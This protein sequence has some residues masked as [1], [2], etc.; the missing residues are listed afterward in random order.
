MGFCFSLGLGAAMGL[1]MTNE[2][3]WGGFHPNY[4]ELHGELLVRSFP[5]V[6][7]QVMV[8]HRAIFFAAG[9][10]VAHRAAV[11]RL[12]SQPEVEVL[13]GDEGFQLL[14][15]GE[16][17]LRIE[18]H[19]EFTTFTVFAPQTGEPFV[20]AATD[21]LPEG[22]L[23]GIPGKTLVAVEIAGELVAAIDAGTVKT[24]EHVL[25]FFD[26]GRLVG[27]WVVERVASV[28]SHF[29]PDERGATRFLVQIH[30]LTSGRYGRLLQ[31]LV[32]IE[33]HR[34]VALLG[35]PAAREL[36]KQVD[37]LDGQHARLVRRIAA[38]EDRTE[39]AIE[40]AELAATAGQLHAQSAPRLRRTAAHAQILAARV[41]ELR[42]EQVPGYPTLGEFFDRRLVPA[43]HSCETAAAALEGFSSRLAGTAAVLQ[44]RPAADVSP[45]EIVKSSNAAPEVVREV[46][47]PALPVE[48]WRQ[49]LEAA[50][51][52]AVVALLAGLL[53]WIWGMISGRYGD[54]LVLLG[55][56]LALALCGYAGWLWAVRHRRGQVGGAASP[57]PHADGRRKRS[58]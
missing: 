57:G 20:E 19:D 10:A 23:E 3:E 24:M 35:L 1:A 54:S 49:P 21:R 29:R 52:V 2:V 32:E 16:V 39:L 8:S 4:R 55:V 43:W 7:G 58:P 56:A 34:M 53:Q 28:W 18:Q 31:R 40:L 17:E 37:L 46:M 38:G 11:S 51:V 48:R 15:L 47:Q 13:S 30:R 26:E 45:V 12:A 6:S 27:G 41:A 25:E 14:R 33:N 36:T 9:E 5:A 42:E 44:S 50:A 22:F